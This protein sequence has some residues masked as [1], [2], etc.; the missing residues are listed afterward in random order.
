MPA[1]LEEQGLGILTRIDVDMTLKETIG[2][3]IRRYVILGARESATAGR[4]ARRVQRRRTRRPS[5]HRHCCKQFCPPELIWT[6]TLSVPVWDPTAT[7]S[8]SQN[9]AVPTF[10]TMYS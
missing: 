7:S 5:R 8:R 3:G 6:N 4:S 2:V 10:D 9:E 1:A